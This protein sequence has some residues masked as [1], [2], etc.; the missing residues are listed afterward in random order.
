MFR[1]QPTRNPGDALIWLGQLEILRR[2]GIRVRG[3]GR[4]GSVDSSEIERLFPH[5]V[6]LLAGGG[7]FGD[8]WCDTQ[9]HREAVIRA[10]HGRRVVQLPQTLCFRDERNVAAVGQVLMDHG[11]VLLTWR[12]AKSHR[13]AQELFPG[14]ESR[15]LPDV[16]FGVGPMER[17]VGAEGA[18]L[19]VARRDQ[20]AG[21]LSA[22]RRIDGRIA[23]RPSRGSLLNTSVVRSIWMALALEGHIRP[24]LPQSLRKGASRA[25]AA[26]AIVQRARG[27]LSAGQVVVSDRLHA[28]VL[29]VLLNIP[30]VMVDTRDGKI[31]AFVNTWTSDC[32]VVHLAT[33]PR[34]AIEVAKAARVAQESES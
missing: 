3:V 24:F 4:M 32:D 10:S 20:E 9:I 14:V 13:S 23:D 7:D 18:I 1:Y 33:S 15:L 8:L 16:A 28:D 17:S 31:G 2:L 34:E 25:I 19:C 22:I 5:V 21:E 26:R 27:F 6:I 12:D 29:C 30:H 11:D